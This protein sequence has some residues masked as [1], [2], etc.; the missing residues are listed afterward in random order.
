MTKLTVVML[1][2]SALAL[3]ACAKPDLPGSTLNG[4]WTAERFLNEDHG[5]AG[6]NGALASEYTELGRRAAFRDVRWYNSTAYIAKAEAAESGAQV[7]PW[8][9]ESL[10]VADTE[11]GQ[12][13]D[14]TVAIILENRDER[15]EACARLQA[16]WDQWLEA[17][18]GG[19]GSCV[20][21]D[22]AFA[23]YQQ[24]KAACL[25]PPV[26]QNFIVY[27]GFDRTN[28]TAR[29]R[30]VL[31][32]VVAAVDSLGATALSIVGHADTV[33]SDGYNQ[34]LSERRARRV[35]G[36]LVDRGLDRNDMT[37][38]GRGERDLARA[39]ADNVREPLNRRVEITLSE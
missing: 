28:L 7:G 10:G 11:A 9:P 32:E 3:A 21:P 33:G 34:R 5:G 15:P 30:E 25:P 17:L 38:A 2:T 23:L 19:D 13:Y 18:R 22:E 31:D 14:E 6:F 27:F 29:A 37:L 26:D 1:A 20:D 8:S 24:A 39:T 16:M 4:T 35:A 36:A 12:L